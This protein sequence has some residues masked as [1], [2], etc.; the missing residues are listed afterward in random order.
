MTVSP[1]LEICSASLQQPRFSQRQKGKET[2]VGVIA[3]VGE[4][5]YEKTWGKQSRRRGSGTHQQFFIEQSVDLMEFRQKDSQST[6]FQCVDGLL[7]A[8]TT[9]EEHGQ[10]I[11]VL[12]EDLE[13]LGY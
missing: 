5:K 8:P 11:E 3:A 7:I 4:N 10:A 1:L 9:E 2:S 12:L 6:L 13:A